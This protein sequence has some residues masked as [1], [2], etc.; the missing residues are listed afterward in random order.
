VRTRTS[1]VSAERYDE[2][3]VIKL[4]VPTGSQIKLA[5]GSPHP[6]LIL[7]FCQVVNL[8]ISWPYKQT[9]RPS[10]TPYYVLLICQLI[11][12]STHENATI[13]SILKKTNQLWHLMLYF[14]ICMFVSRFSNLYPLQLIVVWLKKQNSER[15]YIYNNRILVVDKQSSSTWVFLYFVNCILE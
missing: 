1:W 14:V 15:K 5:F 10:C 7:L 3:V 13:I 4:A 6:H 12:M 9:V 8:V 2:R 11:F